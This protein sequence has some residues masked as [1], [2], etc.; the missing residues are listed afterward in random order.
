MK[1][2]IFGP[3]PSRRLGFSLGIDAVSRKHCTFDCIYCQ[4]GK[5][6]CF[7]LTRSS[8]FNPDAVIEQ[9]IETIAGGRQIDVVSFSGSGEPTLNA[10]LG[11]MIR[12]LKKRVD[13]PVAVITNGSLLFREDV[14][15][16]LIDA[17]IILPS[18]DAASDDVFR[19]INRPHSDLDVSLMLGGLGQ[20]RKEYKGQIWLEVM[21]IKGVN[22]DPEELARLRHA[23]RPMDVD[24]IQLNTLAR[25]PLERHIRRLDQAEMNAAASFFGSRC[26]VISEFE[27][28]S[29]T[30]SDENW[31]ERIVETVMRRSLTMSDI[32]RITGA[33]PDEAKH[34]L[35][36]LEKAGRIRSRALGEEV[37]Y[38]IDL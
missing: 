25:P 12:E 33:P 2:L 21:L 34:H 5:T 9:V 35:E 17:D 23:I 6:T 13:R 3:V 32:V 14:R 20:L 4:V 1:Q 30:Q 37:F 22:D 27:K 31:T 38:Y 16:D 8:F 24:R 18:L 7:D 19:R 26:E 36:Q 10:D 15:R 11:Y 28:T 29:E